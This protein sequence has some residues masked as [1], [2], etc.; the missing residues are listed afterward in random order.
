MQ[1]A[2]FWWLGVRKE[3]LLSRL[4]G[5]MNSSDR[6]TSVEHIIISKPWNLKL[7]SI[8][9]EFCL[10]R[11][12]YP[13]FSK[14]FWERNPAG[15]IQRKVLGGKRHVRCQISE[16]HEHLSGTRYSNKGKCHP[17]HCKFRLNLELCSIVIL[18]TFLFSVTKKRL[19][20]SI[21]EMKMCLCVVRMT[22]LKTISGSVN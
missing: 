19:F 12:I 15:Q 18:M 5:V 2:Q 8:T 14:L 4:A 11:N 10:L 17:I 21:T 22:S 16:I 20:I 6:S 3:E 1:E 13:I 7:I 9:I